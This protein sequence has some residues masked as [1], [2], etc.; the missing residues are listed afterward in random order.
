MSTSPAS[1]ASWTLS[2][3][4]TLRPKPI[5]VLDPRADPPPPL[6][7][8][9]Q[10]PRLHHLFAAANQPLNQ[11]NQPPPMPYDPKSPPPPPPSHLKF[12]KLKMATC[13]QPLESP[14]VQWERGPSSIHHELQ[15]SRRGSRWRQG[16]NGQV[17]RH[18]S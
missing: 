12:S 5:L 11:R 4:L 1:R 17:I 9:P 10:N 18:Y 2:Q 7:P 13:L 14:K 3:T 16:H 6:P 15:G 8:P